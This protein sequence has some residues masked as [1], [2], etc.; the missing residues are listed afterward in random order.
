ME[1]A[2][3][4]A[5]VEQERNSDAVD[6]IA[7]VVGGR[8]ADVEVREAADERR[9]ARQGFDRAEWIAER[10]RHV[11]NVGG[12]ERGLP[13]VAPAGANG[14]LSRRCRR[15][16]GNR[17]GRSVGNRSE[18]VGASVR[19]RRCHRAVEDRCRCGV[20]T[21]SERVGTS[22]SDR[23]CRRGVN[24]RPR[25]KR[26]ERCDEHAP[27]PASQHTLLRARA[28][29]P[30][31][32]R[33]LAPASRERRRSRRRS[34]L[35]WLWLD[36][37]IARRVTRARGRRAEDVELGDGGPGRGRSRSRGRRQAHLV[38]DGRAW[39]ASWRCGL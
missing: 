36:G 15:G 2:L 38:R 28:C 39:S 37:R 29:F 35:E 12:Q 16:A 25:R 34:T 27:D 4:D 10:A 21:R 17:C 1:H 22:V 26:A 20:G 3:A 13:D 9:D 23:R 33:D 5:D 8:A 32:R 19:D 30:S 6:V 18:R 31:S 14:G 11:A 24:L 7:V